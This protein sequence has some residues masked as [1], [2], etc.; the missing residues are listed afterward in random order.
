MCLK[1]TRQVKEEKRMEYV[2][3]V[4][5]DLYGLRQKGFS[6]ETIE[7]SRVQTPKVPIPSRAQTSHPSP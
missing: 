6:G 1:Q 2:I 3:N 5:S 4:F 7:R